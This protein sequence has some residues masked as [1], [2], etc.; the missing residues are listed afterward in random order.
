MELRVFGKQVIATGRE[1]SRTTDGKESRKRRRVAEDDYDSM[2]ER[3]I[4][5][6]KAKDPTLWA[7]RIAWEVTHGAI[8]P[9]QLDELIIANAKGQPYDC[10]IHDFLLKKGLEIDLEYSDGQLGNDDVESIYWDEWIAKPEKERG[11]FRYPSVW[12]H[13]DADADAKSSIDVFYDSA[14]NDDVN[15]R[16]VS[17]SGVFWRLATQ[18][19]GYAGQ[20]GKK[21]Y[22]LEPQ[23]PVN[24]RSTDKVIGVNDEGPYFKISA[25][26]SAGRLDSLEPKELD[27]FVY[28]VRKTLAQWNAALDAITNKEG[29]EQQPQGGKKKVLFDYFIDEVNALKSDS[30]KSDILLD[31]EKLKGL[32]YNGDDII[33]RYEGRG[34]YEDL[35]TAAR[36][37]LETAE[38]DETDETGPKKQREPK[39]NDDP[40]TTDDKKYQGK[41]TIRPLSAWEKLAEDKTK[42]GEEVGLLQFRAE[43]NSGVYDSIPAEGAD[44]CQML[45]ARIVSGKC[46]VNDAPKFLTDARNEDVR[47]LTATGQAGS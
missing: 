4:L 30:T 41:G 20:A 15:Q 35:I 24:N 37:A 11:Q 13:D 9:E 43:I 39:G 34:L 38:A 5:L 36:K 2:T 19:C 7:L 33:I 18:F 28:G 46:A 44:A 27:V 10:Q 32:G 8:T 23:G 31:V 6:P 42:A 26:F 45:A 1:A 25:D 3:Q 17:F 16:A 14:I 12:I 29:K 22:T 47:I 40:P 21:A